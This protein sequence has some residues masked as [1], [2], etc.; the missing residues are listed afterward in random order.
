MNMNELQSNVVVAISKKGKEVITEKTG[1]IEISKLTPHILN[2]LIYDFKSDDRTN[3]R[4]A[5]SKHAKDKKQLHGNKDKV[6]VDKYGTIYAGERRYRASVEAGLTHIEYELITDFHFDPNNYDK[7]LEIKRL[8]D[9]NDDKLTERDE[10]WWSVASRKFDVLNSVYSGIETEKTRRDTFAKKHGM[11]TTTFKQA[12]DLYRAGHVDQLLE[13]DKKVSKD[14]VGKLYTRLITNKK[15]ANPNPYNFISK[16]FIKDAIRLAIREKTCEFINHQLDFDF[17]LDNSG[18]TIEDDECGFE[19]FAIAGLVSHGIAMTTVQAF[20]KYAGEDVGE[21]RTA[22]KQSMTPDIQ[23]P[24]LTDKARSITPNCETETIEVKCATW[25]GSKETHWY[26]QQGFGS[27][28]GDETYIF[29]MTNKNSTKLWLAACILTDKD[30]KAISSGKLHFN[31][32]AENHYGKDDYIMIAGDFDKGN[33][34]FEPEW[35]KVKED[36]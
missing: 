15:V 17:S 34:E 2:K 7:E 33:K 3:L 31:A 16:Q 18:V 14:T 1:V 24:T 20:R 8:Q 29:G 32:W 9:E 22:A 21:I 19:I 13:I 11:G 35:F 25:K 10:S 12:V 30:K 23:F 28:K 27:Q 36:L 6:K 5:L 4:D 26:G